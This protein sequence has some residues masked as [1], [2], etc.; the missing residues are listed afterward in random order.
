MKNRE[1]S[2]R[3]FFGTELKK[4]AEKDKNFRANTMSK[5]NSNQPPRSPNPIDSGQRDYGLPR[6]FFLKLSLR[7]T[8]EDGNLVEMTTWTTGASESL[9]LRSWNR[10]NPTLSPLL[11]GH[12]LITPRK[13]EVQKVRREGWRIAPRARV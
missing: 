3:Y 7:S 11:R 2:P 13:R 6:C 10:K 12:E 4:M 8:D 1:P 9:A 5:N